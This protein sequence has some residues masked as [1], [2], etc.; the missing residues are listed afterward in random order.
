[1]CTHK[2]RNMLGPGVVEIDHSDSSS[3]ASALDKILWSHKCS[4]PI[5]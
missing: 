3:D 5:D 1:M 2:A 4:A